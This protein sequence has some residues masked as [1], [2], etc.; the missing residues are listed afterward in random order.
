MLLNQAAINIEL[1]TGIDPDREAMG[2]ALD[3]AIAGW[4]HP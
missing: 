2:R 4:I 1:W 3:E